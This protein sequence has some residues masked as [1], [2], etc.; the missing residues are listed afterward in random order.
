MKGIASGQNTASTG[1]EVEAGVGSS[2]EK[3]AG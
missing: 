1:E 3:L 2:S